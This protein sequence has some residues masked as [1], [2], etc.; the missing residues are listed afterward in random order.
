MRL[1]KNIIVAVGMINVSFCYTFTPSEYDLA[2]IGVLPTVDDISE[3]N[4]AYSGWMIA[5]HCNKNTIDKKFLPTNA[6]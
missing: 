2:N 5:L 6:S 3:C 1:L 4:I